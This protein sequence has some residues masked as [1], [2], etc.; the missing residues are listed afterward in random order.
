M[1]SSLTYLLFRLSPVPLTHGLL[2]E[3]NSGPVADVSKASRS[4]I[5]SYL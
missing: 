3:S 1:G 5:S 2:S 4:S